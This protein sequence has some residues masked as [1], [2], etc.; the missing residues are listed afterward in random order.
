M[1][2]NLTKPIR[3]RTESAKFDRGKMRRFIVTLYPGDLIGFRLE[4]CRQE[5]LLPIG[6]AYNM[7]IR[8]RVQKERDEKKKSRLVK[9]GKL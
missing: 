9:R 1:P 5:E 2:T 4:K 8:L 7:A 3:R 6:L